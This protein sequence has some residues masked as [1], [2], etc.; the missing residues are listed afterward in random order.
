VLFANISSD[1]SAAQAQKKTKS[2]RKIVHDFPGAHVY[3]TGNAAMAA[4]I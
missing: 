4:D 3:V 2:V 1:T